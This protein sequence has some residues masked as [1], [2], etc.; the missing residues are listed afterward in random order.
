MKKPKVVT[1]RNLKFEGKPVW[2]TARYSTNPIIELDAKLRGFDHL[3]I[4]CHEA[5]HIAYPEMGEKEVRHG[6]KVI[7]AT[8]WSQ[9]Y[10][11]FDR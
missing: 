7:A 2:G 4:L 3:T 10:R 11:R 8:L 9:N 6:A 5:I 1:K